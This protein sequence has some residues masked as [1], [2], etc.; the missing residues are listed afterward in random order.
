MH[1][2]KSAEV[3]LNKVLIIQTLMELPAVQDGAWSHWVVSGLCVT[4]QY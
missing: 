3:P 2:I 4:V 1:V